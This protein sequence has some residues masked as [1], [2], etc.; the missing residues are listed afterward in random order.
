MADQLNLYNE[1]LTTFLGERSLASLTEA[2]GPR[3]Q[4]DGIWD[5]DFIRSLLQEGQWNFAMRTAKLQPED[6]Y[7]PPFGR[8][9]QFVKPDDLV[10]ITYVCRDEFYRYPL[11]EYED[12]ANFLFTDY[13][14]IFVRYVS[15]DAAYGSNLADWP[16]NFTRWAASVLARRSSLLITQNKINIKD[17]KETVKELL[18]KAKS[19]DAMKDPTRTLPSGRWTSSR[20]GS[21]RGQD[22]RH[23][24]RGP[25]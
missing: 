15:D 5:R 1:A 16:E 12:E 3:R 25:A 2:R 4:L 14:E 23:S 19:V 24:A 22:S 6:S 8:Q 10:R 18:V 7:D 11:R 17:L 21:R 13:N 9:F 20:D